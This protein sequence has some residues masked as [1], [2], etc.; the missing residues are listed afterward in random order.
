M[1][2]TSYELFHDRIPKISY[3]KVFRCKCFILN[4]KDSLDK[5]DSKSDEGIFVGYSIRSKA[6]I[7]FNKKT[8]TIEES[9][10]VVFDENFSTDHII[11]LDD[12]IIENITH[13]IDNLKIKDDDT[14]LPRAF[15]EVRDHPHEN[16]LGK[17][18]IMLGQDLN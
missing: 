13:D 8:S 4:T 17:F 9:L 6:Y 3:F 16:V 10:H 15:L 7:I 2:K 1:N 11:Y 18:S 12:D 5:F 14:S